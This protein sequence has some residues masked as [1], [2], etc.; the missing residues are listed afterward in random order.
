M[1]RTYRYVRVHLQTGARVRGEVE[2]TS[3]INFAFILARWNYE[4]MRLRDCK[5]H[6][7]YY[8]ETPI[9]ID[10]IPIEVRG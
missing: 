2:T 1:M 8:P 9:S 10:G 6:W 5:H 3:E 4:G 7:A